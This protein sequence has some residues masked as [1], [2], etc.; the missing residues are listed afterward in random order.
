M[1]KDK[2]PISLTEVKETLSKF[3]QVEDNKRASK[4]LTY[5]KKFV[6]IKPD[7][8]NALLKSLEEL[9]LIKLKRGHLV[10][11]VDLMPEDAEDLKK[12]FV[13]SDI[14]LEQDEINSILERVKKHK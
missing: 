14:T 13:G 10:K 9:D 8:Q 12:I 3:P 5:I 11:I 4:V 6:K 2:V 7:K 1:I